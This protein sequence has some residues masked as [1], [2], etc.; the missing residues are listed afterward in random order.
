MCEEGVHSRREHAEDREA[1][2][3]P[4]CRHRVFIDSSAARCAC[5]WAT[6]SSSG[7]LRSSVLTAGRPWTKEVASAM[8]VVFSGA[9]ARSFNVHD[10]KV[11]ARAR[12]IEEQDMVGGWKGIYTLPVEGLRPLGTKQKQRVF[13]HHFQSLCGIA[14][15]TS[16]AWACPPCVRPAVR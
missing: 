16:R 10:A 9:T 4:L 15:G 12:E 8:G 7:A 11:R 14:S 3:P 5:H 6:T 13:A 2:G 1:R